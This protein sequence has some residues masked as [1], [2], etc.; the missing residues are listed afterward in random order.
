[1]MKKIC[2]F[3]SVLIIAVLLFYL[4]NYQ[5]ST[6]AVFL[7]DF[8]LTAYSL[9]ADTISKM[10]IIF[11]STLIMALLSLFFTSYVHN[12]RF[13]IL[14]AT[15]TILETSLLV[16]FMPKTL[17]KLEELARRLEAGQFQ[18]WYYIMAILEVFLSSLFLS[19]IYLRKK[20]HNKNK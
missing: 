7:G 18:T 15:A 10:Q 16:L 6:E 8:N 2:K 13:P 9:E 11:I 19:L 14:L 3:C 5:A 20:S 4:K 1:M 12:V 17:S